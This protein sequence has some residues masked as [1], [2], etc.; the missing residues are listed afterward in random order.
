MTKAELLEALKDLPDDI[1]IV[2]WRWNGI[3]SVY[4]FPSPACG[5]TTPGVFLL[6]AETPADEYIRM[7]WKDEPHVNNITRKERED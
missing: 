5:L 3:R 2:I 1:E 6:T 4:S 7:L